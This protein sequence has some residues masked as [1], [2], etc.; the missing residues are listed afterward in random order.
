MNK[1]III[2]LTA[3]LANGAIAANKVPPR[4]ETNKKVYNGTWKPPLEIQNK[5]K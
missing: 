3:V 5:V 1:A 2:F 4:V